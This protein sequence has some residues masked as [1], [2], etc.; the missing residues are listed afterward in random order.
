MATISVKELLQA[1]VHYGHRTSRWNPRM[2]P[3]IF[4]KRNRIHIIDLR[5]TL[6]G[7]IKAQRFL[8][9]LAAEGEAILFVGTKRQAAAIIREHVAPRGFPYVADRWLGGMLTN[10]QT[11]RHSLKRLEELEQLEETGEINQFSKKMI[12]MLQ[13]EKRKILRNLEGVRSLDSPPAAMVVVD[14]RR[15]RIA[16]REAVKLH[17]PIVAL[18]DTDCDPQDIDICVPCNDDSIRSI[19]AV[20]V[21][22]AEAAEQGAQAGQAAAD[23]EEQPQAPPEA[24]EAAQQPA[25]A[26]ATEEAEPGDA[27]E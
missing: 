26:A 1:G 4:G 10:F 15:D 11:V 14:P 19:E 3:Y 9:R 16:V 17:I 13:R 23:D 7:I 6:R 22:L 8:G 20:L 5:Q 21:P 12:S 27:S 24:D 2:S 25:A 18:M